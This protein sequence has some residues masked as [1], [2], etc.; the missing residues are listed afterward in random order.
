MSADWQRHDPGAES[1]VLAGPVL[2]APLGLPPSLAG[3]PVI[4]VDGGIRF[5]RQAFLWAGDGDSSAAPANIPALRKRSQDETDLRF[6][7]NGVR[8]WRWR[9]LHLFGFIGARRD[10]ELANLGEVHAELKRRRKFARGV[11]YGE[12]LKPLAVFYPAGEHVFTYKGL[13]SAL[14]FEPVV[15]SLSGKCKFAAENV[16]LEPL[17]GAGISNEAAGEVRLRASGPVAIF[18]AGHG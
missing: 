16:A 14:A 12:G 11:F 10:H 3:A 15:L 18:L 8:G 1:L 9:E 5:A 4:A 13:F 17:S 6:C 2:T 7:L